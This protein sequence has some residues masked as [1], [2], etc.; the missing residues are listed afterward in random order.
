[1]NQNFINHIKVPT[2][3]VDE[4]KA[5]GN[6]KVMAEKAADQKIRFLPHFKPHQSADLG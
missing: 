5:K 2:L 6:L 1:M 3:I 4:A